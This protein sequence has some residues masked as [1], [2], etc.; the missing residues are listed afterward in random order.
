M[1]WPSN[2]ARTKNWGT[3]VLTDSDLEA[4][5]DLLHNWV[6]AALDSTSGHAH[7]GTTGNGPKIVLT[8]AAGVS[9][10]LP[11]A[12][13]GTGVTS[14]S[15]L[16][17]LVYPVGSVYINVS[18]STNPGTLLG[19]GTWAALGAGRMIVGFDSGD[20]NFDSA[21]E[22]GGA[23]TVTLTT[24]ELPAHTHTGTFRNANGWSGAANIIQ[25][26]DASGASG[27]FTSDSTG[28]GASFSVLN[29]Y[30]TCYTW[31]RTA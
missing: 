9:G 20:T 7:D 21:G 5:L 29:K 2:S 27:T 22:T 4:Q 6:N 25:A 8:A 13:G 19:F 17:N 14:L 18:N 10:T 24:N 23:N 1:A 15:S 11:I 31:K 26:S 3:E 30:V 12:N 16:L 28:S